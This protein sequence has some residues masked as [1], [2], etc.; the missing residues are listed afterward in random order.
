MRVIEN[1][2]LWPIA[3]FFYDISIPIKSFFVQFFYKKSP[4]KVFVLGDS[5]TAKTSLTKAMKILGFR[6][7][8][9]LRGERKIDWIPYIDSLHFDAYTDH[10]I[11]GLYRELYEKYPNAKF[12][13]NLRDTEDWYA[14]C[15]RFFSGTVYD[16]HFGP[17]SKERY[18]KMNEE[19]KKFFKGKKNFMIMNVFEGDG[20]PELCE[21]L[22]KPIP[23]EPFPHEN[24]TK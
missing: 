16:A 10:P 14:D 11:R 22:D 21:F 7:F 6:S 23:K 13:L 8:H 18:E 5:K 4:Y 12:I 17:D 9:W 15:R 2:F 3:M 1:R 19:I 20:W 24:R